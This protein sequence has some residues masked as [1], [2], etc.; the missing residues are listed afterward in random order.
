MD[1]RVFKFT[2]IGRE[3]AQMMEIHSEINGEYGLH[4]I[5]FVLMQGSLYTIGEMEHV[6][7]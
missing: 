3:V 6:N 5:M 4:E 2:G 1:N 7:L